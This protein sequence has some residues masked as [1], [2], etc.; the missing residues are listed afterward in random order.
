MANYIDVKTIRNI[1]DLLPYSKE[2]FTNFIHLH[3]NGIED[4]YSKINMIVNEVELTIYDGMDLNQII[5][6]AILVSVQNIQNDIDFE[7][8]ATRL[9]LTRIYI[10]ALKIDSLDDNFEEVYKK[11]FINYIHKGVEQK[12]LDRDFATIFDLEELSNE[13][14]SS[15]DDI[16][17]YIGISTLENRYMVKDRDHNP[18]ETPQF[19]WM[20]V[21]M[22]MSVKEKKPMEQAKIFYQK[23]SNIEYIPGGSTMIG[24]G[25]TYPVLSNCFLLDTEDD[26]NHIFDNVKNVALISKGTGGVG[27]SLSK[28][29][30]EG[31]PIKSNNTF[32]SGPIPFA[33]TLD[34]TIRAVSRAGKKLGAMCMYMENWHINFPE[35]I[36]LKQ[37][38]GDEYRR[39]RTADIAVYI[40][41]EFMKRVINNQEW[42]MFDPA[43][44]PELT[45]L[46]GQEFSD[47]YAEY[48]QKAKAGKM[49]MH[50]SVPAREQMKKI[51]NSLLST[52]HPW[53]TWK[54]TINLRAL[55]NN[56]GTIHCSNLC[57]EVCLPQDRN[58]VAVCNLLSINLKNHILTKSNGK[59]EIDWT[60]LKD[61]TKVGMRHLDN[62]IDINMLTIPEAKKSDENNRAVGLG[63]MGLAEVLEF[64]GYSYDSEEAYNLTDNIIEFISYVTIDESCNLAAERGAYSNFDGSMWSKGYVPYDTIDKVE[65]SRIGK[66]INVINKNEVSYPGLDQ[67]KAK[68]EQGINKTSSEENK[69]LYEIFNQLTKYISN[70]KREDNVSITQQTDD[71]QNKEELL[72]QNRSMKLDWDKLREKVKKGIR[73]ATTMMIAPTASIGLVAGTSPGVDPRFSQIFSRTT[74]SGKFLD[75]NHN[76]VK[77]LKKLGIWEEVKNQVLA[78]YGDLTNIDEIPEE[79]KKVYKTSFQIG[80]DA[81]IEVAS[82]AQKWVDQSIS[83]NMYLDTREVDELLNIYVE[84]WRR[85]LKTTYYLHTKPRH[86]AEQ[87]TVKVNKAKALNKKGFGDLSQSVSTSQTSFEGKD[88]KGFGF[89]KI[90]STQDSLPVSQIKEEKSQI[91]NLK[92]D[93]QGVKNKKEDNI[94]E[95]NIS[96]LDESFIN[97][98]DIQI[99]DSVMVTIGDACPM[100][101]MERA[102]CE[103]CT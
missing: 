88:V 95:N 59:V 8:V 42:F 16:F 54:D 41:D 85:G 47:K 56:T 82:R 58:N 80:P 100:D 3:F 38:A 14:N 67:I 63:I 97:I 25:T 48:I 62:I 6:S 81:F 92:I 2:K 13:I 64:F 55:N 31:S 7:K 43:E 46:Y 90:S 19:T 9:E 37:N 1:G 94:D 32:S 96:N 30:A 75:I 34:S 40:S 57:T 49:R 87:S 51:L 69:E 70:I 61:S 33:H 15:N 28:L 60:K 36:D 103:G 98:Q 5:E 91:M 50:K 102:L 101:P 77:D 68:I 26:I 89:V 20:R 12:L 71:S 65:K 22:G 53:L 99:K 18:I 35:F 66:H 27:I 52:S 83:R 45:E 74:N 11:S 23:L 84:A 86:S 21:A 76:L 17:R 4:A 73:N 29:R 39:T 93:H 44:V 72:V 79:L 24:A 78:N 10:T